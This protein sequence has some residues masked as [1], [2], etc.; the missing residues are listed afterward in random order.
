MQN[1]LKKNLMPGI[2]SSL[3][4]IIIIFHTWMSP[5]KVAV[6]QPSMGAETLLA[7][8]FELATF[9]PELFC[10]RVE[11]SSHWS[12]PGLLPMDFIELQC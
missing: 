12:I 5:T 3:Q 2:S 10:T 9:L 11:L 4:C 7:Q 6:E 1:L 8:G